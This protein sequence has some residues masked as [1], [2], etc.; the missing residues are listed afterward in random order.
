MNKLNRFF[1]AVKVGDALEMS[2]Y[3][4]IGEGMFGGGITP[5]TVQQVLND[6]EQ[7]D[8]SSITL[9]VNSP[10]GD[11]FAGVAIYNL[12]KACSKPVN[13]I[14]DGMAASA[15][16]IVCMA[17]D[18]ICM[19]AGTV[20]MIHEAQG[21]AMGDSDTMVKMA[22]TLKTVTASIADIYVAKTGMSKNKVLEMMK[23]ETWMDPKDAVKQKFATV[24]GKDGAVKNSFN[25]SIFKH[26]PAD[27]LKLEAKTKE[28]AGEHLT[29]GDFIYVGDPDKVDTWA[30]PWHFS[31]DE[32]TKSHLRDALARWDQEEKIPEAHKAECYAK[33]VRL[34]KEHGIEV[35]SPNKP[36]KNEVDHSI[37]MKQIEI[38]KRK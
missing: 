8:Y 11:A 24:E 31:T 7:D 14:V 38:E 33:L 16:S 12:L 20:M 5:Q 30:L 34:C 3:D 17:G 9:R 15:A 19:N 35:S 32:K 25:L 6:D 13:V 21:C 2:I 27:A 1:N 29:A 26:A 28:V 36:P 22:D 18:T 23:E 37:R 10:G 4:A